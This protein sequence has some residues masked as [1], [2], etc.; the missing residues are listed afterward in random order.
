[1]THTQGSRS[2]LCPPSNS[3]GCSGLM[4]GVT[5]APWAAAHPPRAP[6]TL[7]GSSRSGSGCQA[8]ASASPAPSSTCTRG[9]LLLRA[10]SQPCPPAGSGPCQH[11]ARPRCALLPSGAGAAGWASP[12]AEKLL[13]L[14]FQSAVLSTHAPESK[15]GWKSTAQ[16]N[17]AA[18]SPACILRPWVRA[19]P[20]RVFL[21]LG[22]ILTCRIATTPRQAAGGTSRLVP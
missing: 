14:P 20:G 10:P 2:R 18:P 19:L 15:H 11:P 8:P 21:Q 17:A 22:I 5:S 1:M 6:L 16:P 7:R 3:H 9:R 13:N 4:V 12:P